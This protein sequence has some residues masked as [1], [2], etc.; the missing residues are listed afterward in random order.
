MILF[1]TYKPLCNIT[2]PTYCI[3]I[4]RVVPLGVKKI[5]AGMGVNNVVELDWWE[6]YTYMS[7]QGT[8]AEI[9]FAPTKHWTARTLL[10]R[11]QCLWGCFAVLAE[12]CKFF[13]AG[14][15]AYCSIFQQIGAKYGPF[16]IGLYT[17]FKNRA[18]KESENLTI[19]SILILIFC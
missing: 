8:T 10:D 5:L 4:L 19:V 11:N 17:H 2:V 13:F 3:S 15:T 1:Y 6:S 12:K 9:I 14:D 7:K 16:D 18:P